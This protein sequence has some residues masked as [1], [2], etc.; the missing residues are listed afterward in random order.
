MIMDPGINGLQTY[1]QI[2]EMHPQQKAIIVSGYS[3]N[4]DIEKVQELGAKTFIKK[5]FSLTQL[6]LAIKEELTS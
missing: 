5:P 4:E 1:K 2:I 6:G 3:K